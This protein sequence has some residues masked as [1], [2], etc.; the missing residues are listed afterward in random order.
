VLS[1]EK[2]KEALGRI[3]LKSDFDSS[4][5]S[6]IL[7]SEAKNT[8]LSLFNGLDKSQ[9][10]SILKDFDKKLKHLK[11]FTSIIKNIYIYIYMMT[12]KKGK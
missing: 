6:F 1:I 5:K 8:M 12:K 4:P 9:I 3:K 11:G 2:C 10:S 7:N